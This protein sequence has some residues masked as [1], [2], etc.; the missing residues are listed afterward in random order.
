MRI[1]PKSIRNRAFRRVCIFFCA[2]ITM[3]HENFK[4]TDGDAEEPDP[5]PELIERSTEYDTFVG[6]LVHNSE[7][8][9]YLYGSRG[10]GK[11]LLTCH[12]LAA[13]P[14]HT[15]RCYLSCITH[16]THYKVLTALYTA[17]TGEK[18]TTGYHT[19]QLSEAITDALTGQD[20]VVVLDDI[21]FLLLNDGSD[22]LYYLS[23]IDEEH[24]PQVMMISANHPEL[25]EQID[26]RIYS[27]LLPYT[28]Y[29]GPYTE[30]EAIHVLDIRVD[31]WLNQSVTDATFSHIAT[32]S[33]NIQLGRHWLA[34][35]AEIVDGEIT[36]DV[37]RLV[38]SD[39]RQR[40]QQQLL[41]PFTQ[42]HN[43][44]M[45]TIELLAADTEPIRSGAIY[46]WYRDLCHQNNT[47][48]RSTRRLSDYLKHLELL[49]LIRTEYQYG[50]EDGKTHHVWLQEF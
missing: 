15:T 14:D 25:S 42:H 4:N 43:L 45:D 18:P 9:L 32:S 12:A 31:D 49:D 20:L 47:E 17:L 22:L 28:V 33:S 13:L 26:D 5:L 24:A 16:N 21:D 46:D 2:F 3:R 40:Y 10:T 36:E 11:T 7:Q 19:A 6:G 34:V 39:A 41:E 48:P 50:G 44:L 23:R 37:I 1:I 35:A 38:E 27:S 29:L 8:Y 30:D